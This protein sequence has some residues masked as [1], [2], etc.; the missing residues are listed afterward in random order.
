MFI[1]LLVLFTLVSIGDTFTVVGAAGDD[2]GY[3]TTTNLSLAALPVV[4][5]ETDSDDDTCV[6]V[7]AAVTPVLPS[8]QTHRLADLFTFASHLVPQPRAPPYTA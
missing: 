1:R 5:D 3:Q 8:E 6:T 2:R 4:S 7:P